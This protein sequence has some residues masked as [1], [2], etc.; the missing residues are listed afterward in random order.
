MDSFA[1]LIHGLYVTGAAGVA[2]SYW[3]Q[4]SLYWREPK[5]R[6]GISKASWAAW[7]GGALVTTCYAAAV[8]HDL[9]LWGAWSPY[10]KLDLEMQR[11]FSGAASGEGAVYAWQGNNSIGR[12]SMEIIASAAPARVLIQLDMQS[13]YE[14]HNIVEFTLRSKGGATEVSW[15]MDG[16]LSYTHKLVGLFFDM[17]GFI[18]GQFETGLADLKALVEQP[19]A[20]EAA[21]LLL[22]E[23]YSGAMASSGVA[24]MPRV[25]SPSASLTLSTFSER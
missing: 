2:L 23:R 1:T 19:G 21:Q 10:E 4:L 12:G 13:P 25:A 5:T 17:D 20:A 15:E 16:P 14:G 8:V 9:R 7:S 3:P 11:S 6:Q 22:P 24:A 18:G